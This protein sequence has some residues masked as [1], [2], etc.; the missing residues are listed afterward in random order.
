MP[1]SRKLP[2]EIPSHPLPSRNNQHPSTMKFP[3]LILLPRIRE[4]LLVLSFGLCCCTAFA[5]SLLYEKFDTGQASAS[6]GAPWATLG[7]PGT[8]TYDALAVA[9]GTGNCAKVT[10]AK[11]TMPIGNFQFNRPLSSAIKI[12]SGDE[13]LWTFS[14]K[15][16][17]MTASTAAQTT[18]RLTGLNS[19]NQEVNVLALNVFPDRRAAVSTSNSSWKA[20]R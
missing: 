13:V 15:V 3:L 1:S 16:A 6:I 14:L 19:A 2:V 9:S 11:G 10:N 12:S 4:V 5:E 18:V 20:L 8:A 17:A 7:G